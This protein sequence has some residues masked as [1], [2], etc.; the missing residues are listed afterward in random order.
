MNAQKKD[1]EAGNSFRKESQ[2]RLTLP[3]KFRWRQLREVNTRGNLSFS[4]PTN[5][6]LPLWKATRPKYPNPPF[7]AIE[8]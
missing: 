8:R 2:K 1:E 4:F 6:L 7:G 5:I 3:T